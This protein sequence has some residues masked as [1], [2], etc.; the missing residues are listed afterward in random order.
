MIK[1]LTI[2]QMK[3]LIETEQ[4][5]HAISSDYS[6][7]LK[8]DNYVPYLCAAIHNGHQ[9]RK[10]LWSFCTHSAF[11]RWHEEDPETM[12][13][14]ATMP[15]VMAGCDSRFEYDLNR[16]PS[17]AIY[18]DAWGKPLWRKNLPSKMKEVSITKHTAFY[19]IVHT[20]IAQIESKFNC[21][22]VY[23]MHSYNIHKWDR[24]VPTWNIGTENIDNVRFGGV[25]E[26][27]RKS[28]SELALPNGIE[29]TA[30]LNDTFKGNGYFLK[31][32]T[33][34]FSHTLVLATEIA[35]VYCDENTQVVYV[36]VVDAIANQL[37]KKIP[38]HASQFYSSS[39][40]KKNE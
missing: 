27:W 33:N 5:F 40:N 17:E 24:K 9:F 30:L 15:M 20:L 37:S 21:C 8:I 16:A 25:V 13:M 28:L 2:E 32:I 29:N 38:L 39:V 11:E 12:T 3:S 14:V 36:D 23:D 18:E 6:F 7:T 19:E 31:N 22:I 34:K 10:E 26:N 1:R 35:K 4:C